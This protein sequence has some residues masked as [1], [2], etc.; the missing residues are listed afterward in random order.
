M[1]WQA[2]YFASCLLLPV[3]H[4]KGSFFA[5]LRELNVKNR[6]FGPLF[7]DEQACNQRTFYRITDALKLHYDAPRSAVALRLKSLGLL[8]DESGLTR[9]LST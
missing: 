3:H 8:N 2:N 1:E 5:L 7:L 4:F 6:S 9:R